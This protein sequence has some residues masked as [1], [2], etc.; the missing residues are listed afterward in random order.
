M[1]HGR[2]PTQVSY[3]CKFVDGPAKGRTF[4]VA[5]FTKRIDVPFFCEEDGCDCG[6]IASCSYEM[7]FT[8]LGS[9]GKPATR[10]FYVTENE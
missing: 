2:S 1:A 6:G 5:L 3:R 8:L 7:R 9:E 10:L 4:E